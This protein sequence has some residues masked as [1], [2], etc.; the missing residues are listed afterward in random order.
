M[1]IYRIWFVQNLNTIFIKEYEC[2]EKNK[3][4]KVYLINTSVNN[5][6]SVKKEELDKLNNAWEYMYS[7]N[8]DEA[9][10]N[11][12]KNLLI[13]KYNNEAKKIQD[14][15]AHLENSDFKKYI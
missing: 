12:F 2:V 5:S 13:E 3:T 14:K 1:K 8:N 15:I 11:L 7:L 9:T 10:L 6:W 4:Y